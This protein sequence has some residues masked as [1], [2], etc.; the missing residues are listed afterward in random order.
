MPS[1]ATDVPHRIPIRPATIALLA[2]SRAASRRLAAG[3]H[4][5]VRP[6]RVPL[7]PRGSPGGV[8]NRSIVLAERHVVVELLGCTAFVLLAPRRRTPPRGSAGVVVLVRRRIQ[9]P[10]RGRRAPRFRCPPSS[11]W[12]TRPDILSLAVAPAGPFRH[13][14]LRALTSPGIVASCCRNAVLSLL[15]SGE[16]APEARRLQT[17]QRRHASC[18]PCAPEDGGWCRASS[19]PD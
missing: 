16:Y 15:T 6:S 17:A 1:P 11:A 14:F 2:P 12:T 18:F 13:S 19:G 5:P 8:G 7:P 10:A 4:R 9:G 3:L